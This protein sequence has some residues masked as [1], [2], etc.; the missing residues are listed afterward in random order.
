[1]ESRFRIFYNFL[2]NAEEKGQIRRAG[3]ISKLSQKLLDNFNFS[4]RLNACIKL[5]TKIRNT[6]HNNGVYSH[7]NE[8]IL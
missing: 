7:E 3:N 4:E 5:F 1:M 2:F 6:I 8:T